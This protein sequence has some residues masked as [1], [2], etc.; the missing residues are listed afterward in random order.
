MSSPRNLSWE[1]H[2]KGK[3]RAKQKQGGASNARAAMQAKP[4]R[5]WKKVQN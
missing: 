2:E 1:M 4:A 3:L 5:T